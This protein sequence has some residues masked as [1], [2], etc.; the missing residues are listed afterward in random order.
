M[1]FGGRPVASDFDLRRPVNQT[2]PGEQVVLEV[3]KP[4][5]E[6]RVVS[7]VLTERPASDG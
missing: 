1:R 3:V 5:S 4:T 7:I 2:R 6:R